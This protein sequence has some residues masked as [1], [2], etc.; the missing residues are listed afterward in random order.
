MQDS[1]SMV[2]AYLVVGYRIVAIVSFTL[3]LN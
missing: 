2:C 1:H 3:W